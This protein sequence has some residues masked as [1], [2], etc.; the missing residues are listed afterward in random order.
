MDRRRD[1]RPPPVCAD[2]LPSLA[3]VECMGHCGTVGVYVKVC[4]IDFSDGQRW[5]SSDCVARM[6]AAG[7]VPA[8]IVVFGCNGCGFEVCPDREG[9]VVSR[10]KAD[11]CPCCGACGKEWEWTFREGSAIITDGRKRVRARMMPSAVADVCGLKA[12]AFLNPATAALSVPVLEVCCSKANT[13]VLVLMHNARIDNHRDDNT[14]VIE[15]VCW[16]LPPPDP[17]S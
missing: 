2:Q 10:G 14:L 15:R 5:L 1:G 17:A 16:L 4:A 8:G 11:P 13:D 9:M 3:A 12:V 7:Q 6:L